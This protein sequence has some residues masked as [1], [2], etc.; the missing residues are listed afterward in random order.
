MLYWTSTTSS[1]SCPL[2]NCGPY[3]QCTI[4]LQMQVTALAPLQP[5]LPSQ[6]YSPMFED[7]AHPSLPLLNNALFIPKQDPLISDH[8]DSFQHTLQVMNN[9]MIALQLD[10][11]S[12]CDNLTVHEFSNSIQQHSGGSQCICTPI[13]GRQKQKTSIC[14][15]TMNSHSWTRDPHLNM[16]I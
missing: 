9:Q 2:Y 16:N 3:T 14:V 7:L 15:I 1:S 4:L 5:Q 11:Q 6:H 10:L 12:Y 13:F 8:H